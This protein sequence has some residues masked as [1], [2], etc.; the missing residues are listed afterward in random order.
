MDS[1][2][3]PELPYVEIPTL[4]S[5]PW[6]GGTRPEI[7]DFTPSK[8]WI[9]G[10]DCEPTAPRYETESAAHPFGRFVTP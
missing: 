2:F 1:T 10:T 7:S 9:G 8:E 4:A 3:H 6:L 5:A